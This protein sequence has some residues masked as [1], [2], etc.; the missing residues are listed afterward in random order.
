MFYKLAV[1]GPII[2]RG[3]GMG[4]QCLACYRAQGRHPGEPPCA[5]FGAGC[6]GYRPV[7]CSHSADVA[8]ER[9]KPKT[10]SRAARSAAWPIWRF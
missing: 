9:V 5:G 4:Q 2:T 3:L 8:D 10:Q 1:L 7:T 6:L